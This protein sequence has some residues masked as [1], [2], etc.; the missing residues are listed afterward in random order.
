MNTENEWLHKFEIKPGRWVYIP[1]EA[2]LKQGKL[3]HAYIRS[4]W[5]SPLYMFHLRDGGHV[6]AANH[7]VQKKYFALIDIKDFFGATSQSRITRALGNF[8]PYDKAR[9]IAKLSTVK[10]QNGNGLKHVIPYGYPQ[11]PVLASFCFHQSFCGSLIKNISKS[12]D[13]S[14]SIYMDDILLSG[15]DLGRL[16]DT[17]KAVNE[18]L[19]KSGYTVNRSKTQLPSTI[20]NVFNLELSQNS[21]RISAKRIVDFL[22]A[23][24]SSSHP[25]EKKGIAS[26]V[27]SVNKEQARLF[28]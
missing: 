18:A 12:G 16:E 28:K 8:I 4:K 7:H 23:Y 20:V 22:Q 24:I 27:G 10:N 19:V 15:N 3:I 6:A 11:S 21:L 2:T 1:N 25:P 17:F 13:I 14:V 26:Y 9:K 5:K